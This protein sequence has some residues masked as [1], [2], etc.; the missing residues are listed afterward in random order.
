MITHDTK[1]ASTPQGLAQLLLGNSEGEGDDGFAKLLASLQAKGDNIA[2]KP[3]VLSKSDE[4]V[5][6]Q[7]GKSELL[8]L[9]HGS[10][11]EA[12][13]K[14]DIALLDP[15][16]SNT[17]NIK[18]LVQ[19][20]QNAKAFLKEQIVKVSNTPEEPK[21]LKGLLGLAKKVGIDISQIKIESV[22]LKEEV[23]TTTQAK[24]SANALESNKQVSTPSKTAA[25]I[26]STAH[27]S[28]KNSNIPTQKETSST[29][30]PA[31]VEHTTAEIVQTKQKVE[32]KSEQ[33]E[34][35]EKANPLRS[36]LQIS[37]SEG[38]KLVNDDVTTTKVNKQPL[39]NQTLTQLLQGNT[40]SETTT[41]SGE[42]VNLESSDAK[43]TPLTANSTKTDPLTQK[44]VEAKQFVQNF[45]HQLKEEVENYKPPFTRL[46]MKLNPVKLGEVDVT[47]VQRGNNVHINVSSNSAALTLLV[48]NASDLKTQLSNNGI[49]NAS[50]TFNSSADQQNQQQKHT[51]QELLEMYENFENNEDFEL[52]SSLDIVIPRYI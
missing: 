36:L 19:L 12:E 45:A 26:T 29:T 5:E 31:R 49:T 33:S 1:T 52:L 40:P 22:V 21:T 18:Q 20:V 9:L 8:A 6:G 38:E 11:T 39:F 2:S 42:S 43:T 35:K 14:S 16:L 23:P 37:N 30:T 50:M 24:S 7:K 44:M 41:K 15:K 10:E 4:K 47:M 46:K 3:P 51:Q 13:M 27:E 34:K 32:T 17:L 28:L 25:E 48:Q